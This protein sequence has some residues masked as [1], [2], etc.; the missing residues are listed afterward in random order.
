MH[1]LRN[2][3]LCDRCFGAAAPPAWAPCAGLAQRRA[4]SRR[5][6]GKT[7]GCSQ[8]ALCG[9]RS[10]VAALR[11]KQRCSALFAGL[12]AAAGPAGGR[13]PRSGGRTP[14]PPLTQ[15]VNHRLRVLRMLEGNPDFDVGFYVESQPL[16]GEGDKKELL[17]KHMKDKA[18]GLGSRPSPA[19]CAAPWPGAGLGRARGRVRVPGSGG[20]AAVGEVQVHSVDNGELVRQ[21]RRL[22]APPPPPP[23]SRRRPASQPTGVRLAGRRSIAGG[24]ENRQPATRNPQPATPQVHQLNSTYIYLNVF[25]DVLSRSLLNGTHYLRYPM[26]GEGLL[27]G[28]RWL[29]AN[30]ALAAEMGQRLRENYMT[31]WRAEGMVRSPARPSP[32]RVALSL[33]RASHAHPCAPVLPCRF[34]TRSR[35]CKSMPG[36]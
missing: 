34:G 6:G 36:R 31:R 15:V 10:E 18:R 33:L 16:H 35:C 12:W 27:D 29:K 1:P 22:G 21:P 14:R 8:A 28:V 2:P 26:N 25:D 9:L 4:S 17:Y 11:R 13:T 32:P 19:C 23:R 30:D 7:T 5:A 20:D 24:D 3:T